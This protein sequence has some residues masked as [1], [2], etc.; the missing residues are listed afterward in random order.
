MIDTLGAHVDRFDRLLC[1]IVGLADPSKPRTD[2]LPLPSAGE[3]LPPK[4][5]KAYLGALSMTYQS[6]TDAAGNLTEQGRDVAA[7]AIWVIAA[8]QVDVLM[9]HAKQAGVTSK[10]LANLVASM[11]L[12][13]QPTAPEPR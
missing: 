6:A 3:V 2:K 8:A 11:S 13:R 12:L 10:K 4:G 9:G 1:D 7:E 5:V